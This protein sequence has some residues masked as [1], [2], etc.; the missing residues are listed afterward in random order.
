[1]T[2][3]LRGRLLLA[4]SIPRLPSAIALAA[5]VSCSDSATAPPTPRPSPQPPVFT[6]ATEPHVVTMIRTL[7]VEARDGSPAIHETLRRPLRSTTR[8][9]REQTYARPAS[10][11]NFEFDIAKL[12]IP[13]VSL[14]ARYERALCN[15]Q[16]DW[17]RTTPSGGRS[18]NEIEMSGRGDGPATRIRI[19]NQGRVVATV[20]RDWRRTPIAWQLI[21]QVTSGSD[22]YRD[23]ITFERAAAS[24]DANR[25]LPHVACSPVPPGSSGTDRPRGNYAPRRNGEPM[26]LS[27]S[28]ETLSYLGDDCGGDVGGADRCFDKQQAVYDAD[29]VLIAAATTMTW[30]C[31]PPAVLTGAPC[32]GAFAA[33]MV[34]VWKLYSAQEALNHCRAQPAATCACTPRLSEAAGSNSDMFP[35]LTYESTR[36]ANIPGVALSSSCSGD[37]SPGG[38]SG[39]GSGGSS[40]GYSVCRWEDWE[41]SY[42]GGATWSYWGTFWTCRTN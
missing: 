16:R 39:S 10:Q 35:E 25:P 3:R 9:A 4:A 1:M 13:P 33:Y 14:P 8:L 22:G 5:L 18:A 19:L 6:N 11:S 15:N 7:D 40:G 17:T 32:V 24:S 41:I 29:A 23:V 28:Q 30:L 21:R 36:G 42:D 34:A 31:K 12:P 26:P 20:E 27:L 38:S 37:G 2:P